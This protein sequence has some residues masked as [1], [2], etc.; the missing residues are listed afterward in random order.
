M[1][2]LV[3]RVI[4]ITLR[5]SNRSES[6]VKVRGNLDYSLAVME[7][8]IRN[9]ELINPCPNSDTSTISYVTLE[10]ITSTFSCVNVPAAGYVA[11]GSARLTSDEIKITACSFTCSPAS[12]RVPQ[13]VTI[14]LEAADARA[15]G[16][17]S[18]KVTA[19]TKIFLRTY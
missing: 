14:S 1:G 6:L 2:V 5:G 13:A 9:A 17:E 16:I 12:G 19:T 4:L 8:Q 11:S 15:I 10:R 18:A 3:G 7:R